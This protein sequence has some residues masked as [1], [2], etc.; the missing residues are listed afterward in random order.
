MPRTGRPKQDV[1]TA[2]YT[3]M[4][5]NVPTIER[6]RDLAAARGST[7]GVVGREILE[8]GLAEV[9]RMMGREQPTLA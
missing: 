7:W 8:R 1:K 4:R 9:E 6:L 5:V 3:A 2:T